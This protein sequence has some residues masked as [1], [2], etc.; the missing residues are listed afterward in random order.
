MARTFVSR[1]QQVDDLD[2]EGGVKRGG[3]K[4][5]RRDYNKLQAAAWRSCGALTIPQRVSTRQ[6]VTPW[7]SS[8]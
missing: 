1:G 8:T 3:D 5:I 7:N 2:T 4:T 6:S